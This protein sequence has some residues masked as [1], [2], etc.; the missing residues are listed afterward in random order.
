MHLKAKRAWFLAHLYYSFLFLLGE[1]VLNFGFGWGLWFA[2]GSQLPIPEMWVSVTIKR[3]LVNSNHPAVV[4]QTWAVPLTHWVLSFITQIPF[5][6]SPSP[7]PTVV[8]LLMFPG[9]QS[10][11]TEPQGKSLMDPWTYQPDLSTGGKNWLYCRIDFS[12]FWSF[13]AI[14]DSCDAFEVLHNYNPFE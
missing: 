10:S 14:E 6:T 1:L 12:H 7:H 9:L 8:H 4:S 11:A 2:G 5:P 13:E 3:V